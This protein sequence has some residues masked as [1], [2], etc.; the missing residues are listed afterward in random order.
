[1]A[2]PQVID[3]GELK[4]EETIT[5]N[6]DSVSTNNDAPI[7]SANF[8]P[9]AE[10]LMN[11]KKK[12]GGN[13]PTSDINLADLNNLENELNDLADET[14]N[15]SIKEARSVMFENVP[16]SSDGLKSLSDDPPI[17]LNI[18][19]VSTLGNDS[20]SSIGLGSSVGKDTIESNSDKKTW[21]GFGKFNNIPL[22]PDANVAKKPQLTR[23]E[24]LREKFK[25][26]KKLEDLEKKGVSLSK[27]YSMDSSLDEM[28][29][30][31][32]MIVS[33]KE[34]SNSI[35]FQGKM[36]MSCITGL[37]FLN[38]KFDPFDLKLDGWAE[39]VDENIDEYDEIFSELHEKYK[40]KSKIA[41]ELKLMFQLG[42]SAIM[43]HMT[44]SMFRSSMPSM[45]DVMRQNP[46][47]MQQFTQAAVNSMGEQNPG[48]SGFM[49]NMMN[50]GQGPPNPRQGPP[51]MRPQTMQHPSMPMS[52]S[53]P[54]T[55]RP[56]LSASRGES[57]SDGIDIDSNFS[58]VND[59]EKSRPHQ[60]P[61]MKGPSDL[62]DILSGL[63]TKQIN[64]REN[65]E[66][67][68]DSTISIK[69]LKETQQ[70]LDSHKPKK[71]KKR[72]KSEKNVVS[73]DL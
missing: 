73:L 11:D 5:L 13:T 38:N 4:T 68:N 17:K 53:S 52:K 3:I 54:P 45:D 32:E 2:D 23:E 50:N 8:G 72:P 66:S 19:D 24:T 12:D 55:N 39:Q 47:L 41:P 22:N 59:V 33:E 27:E 28:M 62:G 29:G 35:K 42:G 48:F 10:L 1:M 44:N 58:K 51:P 37:E 56:D 57:V 34:K 7:R 15:T 63:K 31:Y 46:D 64:I 36:L 61:D 65:K 69:E 71:S 70:L 20:S 6:T 9:G 30:E 60:R 26:L 67:D 43:L 40:S 16:S 25:Y 21:D 14:G 49:N 18:E